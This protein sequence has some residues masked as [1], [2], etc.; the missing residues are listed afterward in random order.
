MLSRRHFFALVCALAA[1]SCEVGPGQAAFLSIGTG[2]TGGVYY[3]LGG[4]LANALSAADSTRR[5]TAEVTGGSVENVNRVVAGQIDMGFS[6]AVAAWEEIQRDPDSPLRIAAP[7]YPNLLH[8]LVRESAGIQSIADLAGRRVSVGSAGSGTERISEQI[9]EAW[10]LS[11]EDVD[12]QFLSFG[13]SA[14]ALRDGALDAAIMSVG[15]PASAV[16]DATSAGGI[17]VLAIDDDGMDRVITAHPYYSRGI[18]PPGVYPS[19][20]AEIPTLA[21]M[22]WVVVNAAEEEDVV[23]KLLNILADPGVSFAR[24][25]PMAQQIDIEALNRAPIPL[26]RAAEAWMRERE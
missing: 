12:V 22:N 1:A 18:V 19:V 6:L 3:P 26:H 5:Y 4:G 24:V 16:L 9:L 15:Y 2:G 14:S 23:Q 21:M 10:G 11:Y 7:L 17:T 13:E 25:H 8:V 20:D